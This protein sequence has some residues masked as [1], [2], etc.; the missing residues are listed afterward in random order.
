MPHFVLTFDVNGPI[1]KAVIGVTMARHNAL[2]KAGQ[3]VPTPAIAHLLVDTGA[4]CTCIDPSILRQLGL[5][6]TGSVPI[7]TPST[8]SQ[9]V[10]RDQYDVG[11][12]I[13]GNTSSDTL[14]VEAMPVIESDFKGQ[15]IDGLLGRDVLKRCLV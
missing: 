7:A 14:F 1:V 3:P 11:F 12:A 5:T 13:M 15:G 10:Q 4:S 2:T 6:P 9:T 8:G